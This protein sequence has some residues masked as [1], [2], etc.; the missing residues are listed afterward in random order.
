MPDAVSPAGD[1][2]LTPDSGVVIPRM[3]LGE[4]GVL[5]L[6]IRNRRIVEEA[7]AAFR[8]PAF[9]YT[10][11]EMRN[12]P[13]VAAAMNVYRMLISRVTWDFVPPVDARDRQSTRLNSSY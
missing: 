8:Y 5:G 12:N 10:V 1:S 2:S 13:T 4:Q 11:R 7:Q 6:P 9:I 3:N